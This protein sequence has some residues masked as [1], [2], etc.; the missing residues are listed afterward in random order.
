M[1]H[2]DPVFTFLFNSLERK[3]EAKPLVI[4]KL[5]NVDWRQQMLAKRKKTYV[6]EESLATP[7]DIIEEPEKEIGYGLQIKK[8]TKIEEHIEHDKD[9]MEVDATTTQVTEDIV[10]EKREETLE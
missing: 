8:R 4:P 7:M 2:T 1:N 5:D 3:E 10:T 9:S 6:P